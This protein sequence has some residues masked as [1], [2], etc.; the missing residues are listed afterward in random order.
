MKSFMKSE[1]TS[2]LTNFCQDSAVLL[3]SP[4]GDAFSFRRS[5]QECFSWSVL[6]GCVPAEHKEKFWRLT[7][8]IS[9]AEQKRLPS[10]FR[11]L[12]YTFFYSLSSLDCFSLESNP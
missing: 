7:C 9:Q 10:F 2:Q 3:L 1:P 5:G 8:Q 11:G 12:P 4:P 6:I